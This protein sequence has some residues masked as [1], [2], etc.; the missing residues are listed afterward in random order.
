MSPAKV[1]D[2]S[3]YFMSRGGLRVCQWAKDNGLDLPVGYNGFTSQW[4]P[5]VDEIH[6]RV[7]E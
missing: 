7:K 2:A 5:Y 6:E 1:E 4:S 3:N